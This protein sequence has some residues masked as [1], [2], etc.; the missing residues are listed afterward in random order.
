MK[1][2]LIK[3]AIFTAGALAPVAAMAEGED[4]ATQLSTAA[5]GA[6]TA[7]VAVVGAILV[8][9]MAI[10]VARKTYSLIKSALGRA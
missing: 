9:G 4:L 10:P 1:N 7:A 5:T 6:I 3:C 2:R 8:A